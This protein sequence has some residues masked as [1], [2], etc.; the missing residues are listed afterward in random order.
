MPLAVYTG[1]RPER[2]KQP[3]GGGQITRVGLNLRAREFSQSLL[4]CH[5][6]G[7]ASDGSKICAELA[8]KSKWFV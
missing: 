8:A 3:G 2:E 6:S 4:K 7:V 1:P 5:S